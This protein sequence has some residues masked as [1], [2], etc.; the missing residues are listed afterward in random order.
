MPET[1][2]VALVT[3]ASSGIGAAFARELARRGWNLILVARRANRLEELARELEAAS[4]V[5]VEVLPSDLTVDSDLAKV[6]ERIARAGNLELLVN[7]AG[8][9]TRGKFFE[10][11]LEGQERMH[12]LHVLAA[13]RLTHAALAGM[14]ARGRG[15]LINVSS[16]AAF[17]STPGGVSYSATKAW[18][19][20]FTEALALELKAAGSPV[21]VQALCPGFTYTEF[22]DVLKIDRNF[23]SRGWWMSAE[24]VVAASLRGLEQGKL[25]VVPGLRYKLM[26]LMLRLM[27]RPLRHVTVIVY[28][29]RTKRT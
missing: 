28:A 16:V 8:F 4:G 6:A 14:V 11:E 19:N 26:V 18:M 24:E 15:S 1:R 13:M 22:H 27:P 29:R 3:G 2:R 9:G 7:N 12:R 25:I 20:S 21:R 23:I 10:A 17:G 5:R